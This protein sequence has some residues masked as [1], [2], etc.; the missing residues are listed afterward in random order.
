M[1]TRTAWH[2]ARWGMV[3]LCLAAMM[4][5]GSAWA[6]VNPYP[7]DATFGVNLSWDDDLDNPQNREPAVATDGQGTWVVAWGQGAATGGRDVVTRTSTDNGATWGPEVVAV[8]FSA[9]DAA[10]TQT[11][12]SGQVH[13]AY[14]DGRWMV[15]WMARTF[16]ANYTD[17][18]DTGTFIDDGNMRNIG[19][20]Y[21]DDN[22]ATWS[23]PVNVT[24]N[25]TVATNE[26]WP[27]VLGIGSDVWMITWISSYQPVGGSNDA[28]YAIST[29]NG[30]TWSDPANIMPDAENT[31]T[32]NPRA[33]IAMGNGKIMAAWWVD[34]G[35]TQYTVTRVYD[36]ATQAWGSV[37]TLPFA[38]GIARDPGVAYDSA[39][40]IW[41]VTVSDTQDVFSSSSSDGGATWSAPVRVS[42][43]TGSGAYTLFTTLQYWDGGGATTVGMG[44]GG[45]LACIWA[46][47]ADYLG[48][49]TGDRDIFAAF[50]RDGGASWS[51]AVVVNSYAAGDVASDREPRLAFGG[52]GKALAIWYNQNAAVGLPGSSTDRNIYASWIPYGLDDDADGIINGIEGTVESLVGEGPDYLNPDTDADADGLTDWE[53]TNNH[54]TDPMNPDTD[55]DGLSDADEVLIH[56]TD[57]LDADTDGDGLSDADEINVHGTDPLDPDTDGDGYSDG[58]EVLM[59]TDPLDPNDPGVPS[60]ELLSG[61]GNMN[62]NAYTDDVV[63]REP[64][65]AT[66]GAG[67][68]I[69]V[70]SEQVTNGVNRRRKVSRTSTDNGATWGP[71]VTIFDRGT[72][73]QNSGQITVD[74]TNGTW[75]ATWMTRST[76]RGINS[77]E[78]MVARSTDNGASWTDATE[79]EAYINFDFGGLQSNWPRVAGMAGASVAENTWVVVWNSNKDYDLGLSETLGTDRDQFYVYSTDNGVTWSTILPLNN[80]MLGTVANDTMVSVASGNGIFMAVGDTAQDYSGDSGTDADI[81]CYTTADP[82]AGWS[83]PVYVNTGF[84]SDTVADMRPSVAYNEASGL[85]MVSWDTSDAIYTATSADNGATWSAPVLVSHQFPTGTANNTIWSWLG[86]WDGGAATTP[87]TGLGGAWVCAWTSEADVLGTGADRD[88]FAAF[89][90]DNGATWGDAF[91]MNEYA[92]SD[93]ASDRELSAAF[94]QD[95]KA[96]VV[97]YNQTA[98]AVMP[99]SGNDLDIWYAAVNYGADDDNDGVMNGLEGDGESIPGGGPDFLNPNTDYDGDGLS[100]VA[101][102]GLHGT[103]PLNSDSDGDGLSDGEEVNIHGTDPL[104]ADTDGDGFTD[105]HE[106]QVGSDPLDPAS[107]PQTILPPAASQIPVAAWPA[108]IALLALGALL[109]RR[110]K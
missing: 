44:L 71:E 19:A 90:T 98:V 40:D 25:K 36:I 95:G 33:E 8:D 66:D 69:S 11:K 56:G 32:D 83:A 14:S 52:D 78:I 92:T 30:A 34:D 108:G 3:P 63:D 86:A 2:I 61:T 103:D 67:T 20:V 74:Y 38:G 6:Q 58:Q 29:D 12:N 50:S 47:E 26:Q 94:G 48:A 101:E 91:I 105:G 88:I 42:H 81:V 77:R 45:A 54:G 24:G 110:R 55:G 75:V 18:L 68:W 27:S 53:E 23:A 43:S 72:T 99:G 107:T 93:S 28:R 16:F 13:V 31:V 76:A 22:G 104:D 62:I 79:V 85:W 41:V 109:A 57:P 35:S 73:T 17:P 4:I 100:D 59:G 39:A 64:F 106:V 80:D 1:N 89:S 49:Q 51:D 60:G 102:T 10:W 97:W 84:A 70:W 21:S 96:I 9:R 46:S 87:G 65:I 37:V 82:T 7:V 15:T 5:A